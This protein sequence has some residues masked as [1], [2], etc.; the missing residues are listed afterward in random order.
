MMTCALLSY[1]D[2]CV[3]MER[4]LLLSSLWLHFCFGLSLYIS[5]VKS[6]FLH[7]F[8]LT[9][10]HLH[11]LSCS[12]PNVCKLCPP[13]DKP[14]KSSL[15]QFPINNGQ[16]EW[17]TKTMSYLTWSEEKHGVPSIW[18]K[19]PLQVGHW[20]FFSLVSSF[21]Q[22]LKY[23]FFVLNFI[24]CLTILNGSVATGLGMACEYVI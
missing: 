14:K 8:A 24:H 6:S 16:G 23:W 13:Q 15:P 11:P 22:I 1:F 18:N 7:L 19:D 21:Q 9:S 4:D 3:H 2:C 17:R 5:F 10:T 12:L 20:T